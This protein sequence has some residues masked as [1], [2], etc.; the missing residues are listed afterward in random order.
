MKDLD[1]ERLHVK[2]AYIENLSIDNID[3]TWLDPEGNIDLD[4]IGDTIDSL[5]DGEYFARARSMH[6]DA[7]TGLTLKENQVY[8]IRFTP[9]TEEKSIRRQDTAP[10]SP[11]TDEYWIDTSGVGSV[12]KRW[13]GSVWLTIDQDE[14]DLLNRG[15]LTT[16]AKLSSLSVDGLVLL[17]KVYVDSVAG[18]YDLI[19]RTDIQAGHLL[20]SSVVQSEFYRTLSDTEKATYF[21]KA[22]TFRQ[23]TAPTTGMVAGDIWIDTDNGDKP[24]TYSATLGWVAAYTQISGGCLTTGVIDC[25]LVTIQTAGGTTRVEL[26][27]NGLR[28]YNAGVL[29]FELR[30][31]DGRGY[32]GAGAVVLSATG[33]EIKGTS[34]LKFTYGGLY[35]AY[36][37]SDSYG[38]L[39]FGLSGGTRGIFS[40]GIGFTENVAY[41]DLPQRTSHPTAAEGRMYLNSSDHNI[42]AYVSGSWQTLHNY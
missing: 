39:N 38:N 23:A 7:E 30:A 1:L 35:P 31:S 33:L 17:D 11:T 8:Y 26:T 32:A 20:L 36:I 6:L 24:Y 15:V 2:D 18:Q 12:I 21:A 37:Y 40:G 34:A 29:Q 42:Y 9:D 19:N 14:I 27:A 4:K 10:T 13:T 3:A 16:H 22:K 28:G 41:I 5:P 25:S